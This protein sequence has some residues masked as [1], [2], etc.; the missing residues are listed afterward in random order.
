VLDGSADAVGVAGYTSGMGP[1]LG[2]WRETGGLDCSPPVASI[3]DLH[4][5]H[6]RERMATMARHGAHLSDALSTAGVPHTA[7]KGMDTAYRYFPEPGARPLSDID[8]LIAPADEMRAGAVLEAGGFEAGLARTNPPERSWRMAGSPTEPRTLCFVHRDDPWTI[9]LHT[10]L[11]RRYAAA[12]P[13][14]RLDE[15][16]KAIQSAPHPLWPGARCLPQPLHLL[17]LAVHAGCGL[18]NLTMLRLVE[19]ALVI[20]RDFN[21]EASWDALLESAARGGALGPIYPALKLCGDL[22]PGIVPVEVIHISREAAPLNVRRV[23]EPLTPA[24]AQRVLRCSLA[25]RFMW[26]PSSG[27]RARQVVQEL[28]PPGSSSPRVLLAIYRTRMWRLARRTLT[29]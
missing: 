5:R 20:R 9:D 8:L 4:L 21:D 17:H 28:F 1:L 10:S 27:T 25:E 19:L 12:T 6:N 15:A 3:L 23:V 13:V 11:N 29:K 18:E 22:V 7:L 16:A 26:S 24:H 2:Y 14:I